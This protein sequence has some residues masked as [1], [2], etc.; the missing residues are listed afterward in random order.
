[1]NNHL[2]IYSLSTSLICLY[3]KCISNSALPAKSTPL[4]PISKRIQLIVPDLGPINH[5]WF[6]APFAICFLCLK[7]LVCMINSQMLPCT[8]NWE[9]CI[10]FLCDISS[11]YSCKMYSDEHHW[12]WNG[13]RD[14]EIKKNP[15]IYGTCFMLAADRQISPYGYKHGL[16]AGI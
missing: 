2:C 4:H 8:G 11:V 5:L 6:L 12:I 14:I 9:T 10:W 16:H 1:M 7:L 3:G 15:A 13:K